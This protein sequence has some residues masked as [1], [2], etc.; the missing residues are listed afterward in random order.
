MYEWAIFPRDDDDAGRIRVQASTATRTTTDIGDVVCPA[1]SGMNSLQNECYST[2][3]KYMLTT[4]TE[5]YFL[6]FVGNSFIKHSVSLFPQ[7]SPLS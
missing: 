4:N 5:A 6:F 7:T 1:L 2:G 3:F